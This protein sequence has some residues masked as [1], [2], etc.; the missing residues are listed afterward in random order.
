MKRKR[1]YMLARQRKKAEYREWK[2]REAVKLS[3]SL[4][5]LTWHMIADQFINDYDDEDFIRIF[6]YKPDRRKDETQK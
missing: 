4:E 1:H 2:R 3:A 6:G 5:P